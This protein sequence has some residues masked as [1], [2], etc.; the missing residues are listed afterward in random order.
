MQTTDGWT[1]TVIEQ[2]G[3]YAGEDVGRLWIHARNTW[4]CYWGFGNAT[5]RQEVLA[6]AQT[7]TALEFEAWFD[8]AH[9][10]G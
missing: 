9:T 2:E 1:I 5:R 3:R 6:Q 7:M 4:T 8:T 10:P